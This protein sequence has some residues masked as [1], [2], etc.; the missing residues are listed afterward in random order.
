MF[1]EDPSVALPQNCPRYS[2]PSSLAGEQPTAQLQKYNLGKVQVE[3]SSIQIV[4]RASTEA[5]LD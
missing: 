4:I 2:N 3:R 1:L 5:V